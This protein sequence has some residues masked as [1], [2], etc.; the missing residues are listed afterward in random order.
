[1]SELTV[2]TIEDLFGIPYRQMLVYN[3]LDRSLSPVNCQKMVIMGCSMDSV[4]F[5]AKMQFERMPHMRGR[6]VVLTAVRGVP[7]VEWCGKNEFQLTTN[8]DEQSQYIAGNIIVF[9]SLTQCFEANPAGWFGANICPG[10]IQYQNPYQQMY[11]GL[12]GFLF[13]MWLSDQER[14][15]FVSPFGRVR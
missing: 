11:S 9:N 12:H 3:H 10:A 2:K 4:A 6:Q 13:R 5:A 8:T 7:Q 14:Q 1:M 15:K